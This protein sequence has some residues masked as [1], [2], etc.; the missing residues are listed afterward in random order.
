MRTSKPKVTRPFDLIYM[1][2][3]R[4]VCIRLLSFPFSTIHFLGTILNAALFI[5]YGNHIA[6]NKYIENILYKLI[7]AV[8]CS[9]LLQIHQH[10]SHC[11]ESDTAK[12]PK[13]NLRSGQLSFCLLPSVQ[14]EIPAS[15]FEIP[16]VLFHYIDQPFHLVVGGVASHWPS[17]RCFGF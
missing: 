15:F 8:P 13:Q 2:A 12:P 9:L 14:F 10:A 4:K 16:A 11:E 7:A 3:T 1:D 5:D 17:I 6:Y